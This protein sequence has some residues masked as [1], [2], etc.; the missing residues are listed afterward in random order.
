M[1][2]ANEDFTHVTADVTVSS[3]I[4]NPAFNGF[5]QFI[6]PIKNCINEYDPN[7]RIGDIDSLLPL[8]R[9]INAD[10]TVNV[11]NYLLDEVK[12]GKTI[13]IIFTL[14]RKNRMTKIKNQPDCSFLEGIPVLH[15]PLYAPAAD[16]PMLVQYMKVF[17]M[18]LN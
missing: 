1:E 14:T 17:P 4:N 6:F 13:F 16:F 7:M 18:L 3:V 2:K 5:G 15:L 8:H 12:S 9:N 11:I 10:T